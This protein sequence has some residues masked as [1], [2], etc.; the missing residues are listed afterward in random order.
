MQPDNEE[1]LVGKVDVHRGG[2]GAGPVL[3]S[4]GE[5]GFLDTDSLP[6]WEGRKYTPQ[7]SSS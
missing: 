1:E 3:G 4:L 2:G 7:V 6:S 5:V